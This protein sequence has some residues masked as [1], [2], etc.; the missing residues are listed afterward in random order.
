M[1]YFR[2]DDS[3]LY[4]KYDGTNIWCRYNYAHSWS[5]STFDLKDISAKY[6]EI[7]EDDLKFVV[8]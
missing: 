7:S 2:T 6:T 3:I 8:S 1:R 4:F 5:M